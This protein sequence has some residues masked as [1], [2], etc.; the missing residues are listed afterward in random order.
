MPSALPKPPSILSYATPARP[1]KRTHPLL[2]WLAADIMLMFAFV[3]V[4]FVSEP[5]RPIDPPASPAARALTTILLIAWLGL[6]AGICIW[7]VT[8][9]WRGR[10]CGRGRAE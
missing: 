6:L 2:W 8:I 3:V 7:A 9:W 10:G 1:A 5:D 4:L